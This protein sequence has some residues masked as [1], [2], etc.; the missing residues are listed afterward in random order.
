MRRRSVLLA[1]L[2]LA[3][4]LVLPER[5]AIAADASGAA[6]AARG[7]AQSVSPER[8]RKRSAAVVSPGDAPKPLLGPVSVGALV[9]A[10]APHLLEASAF[11]CYR[12]LLALGGGF[13][14][15]PPLALTEDLKVA[16]DRAEVDLRLFPFRGAFFVG[17]AT[18]WARTRGTM[19]QRTRAF[20]VSTPTVG[21]AALDAVFVAPKLGWL[22]RLPLRM[23]F[24]LDAAVELPVY[25]SAP[26][27]IASKYGLTLPVDGRGKLAS[28]VG[29]VGTTPIPVVSARLGWVL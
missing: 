14:M 21:S 28:V 6:A 16:R 27:F 23:A 1:P 17:V 20:R 9:G 22:W 8:A 12:R 7:G 26:E 25:A 10:G 5:S 3:L 15:L 13:G 24:G 18:G 11:V 29:R 2:L 19:T 4:V